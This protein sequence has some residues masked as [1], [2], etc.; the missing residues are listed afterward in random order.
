MNSPFRWSLLTGLALMLFGS[1]VEAQTNTMPPPAVPAESTP[2]ASP[3]PAAA[4]AVSW[5]PA[6]QSPLRIDAANGSNVRFGLLMQPQ[7]QA[8]GDPARDGQSYNLFI[9]RTRIM[10]GGS[11]FGVFEYFFDTD[12]PN[13]FLANNVAGDGG[14]PDT[15]VKNTPGMNIQDAFI[16][17]KALGDMAKVDAGYM[18]PPLAHNAVQGATS[19][20]GWDYLSY[21]FLSGNAFGSSGNPIGRD[22]GVQVR[23][24]V[25]GGHLEYR[26]GLFQ[27]L[28]SGQTAT[29]PAANNFFRATGRV[30]FNLFDAET[31]FFYAGTYLGAKRIL[32]IGASADLQGD[33]KYFAG[34]VFADLPLG[35]G[36]LTA[37]ANVAYWDGG[38]FIPVAEQTALMAEAGYL[39]GSLRLTPIIRVEQL[40]VTGGADQTRVGGGLAFWPYGHNANVKAFYTNL[41]VEGVDDSVG[42]FNLQWQL[43]FF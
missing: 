39:I 6:A 25:L 22:M 30:Q 26:A 21:S 7:F 11:L 38:G 20:L 16:T 36:V 18:L 24:L 32:S 40:W 33:Y 37:Q 9:R 42:Q 14:A 27:G 10:V 28:R 31:G 17:Y 8:V 15:A 3:P 29:D 43:Y 13:L 5:V 19:L 2:P 41:S 1:G 12:Y 23:G 35:P 34:D 4:P